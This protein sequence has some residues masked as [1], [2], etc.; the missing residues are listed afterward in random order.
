MKGV[1]MPQNV[2]PWFDGKCKVFCRTRELYD[3]AMSWSGSVHGSTYLYP[4]KPKAYDVIIPARHM[5]RARQL[6]SATK[7]AG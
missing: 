6:L 5:N 7:K 1:C 4:D 2:W 3:E